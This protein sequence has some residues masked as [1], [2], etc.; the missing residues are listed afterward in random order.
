METNFKKI[1]YNKYNFL[2]SLL[3][4][5]LCKKI[6]FKLENLSENS[7]F[8]E[9]FNDNRINENYLIDENLIKKLINSILFIPKFQKIINSF[10]NSYLAIT[11]KK[12]KNNT[13]GISLLIIFG[14]FNNEKFR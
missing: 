9:I 13:K 7:E 12:L 6:T 8:Q 5:Y 10:F 11:Y 1:F 4:L 3:K 14:K 2:K